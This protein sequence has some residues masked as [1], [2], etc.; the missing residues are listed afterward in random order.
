MVTGQPTAAALAE[1]FDF[2]DPDGRRIGCMVRKHAAIAA[3]SLTIVLAVPAHA[4]VNDSN[5]GS[6]EAVFLEEIAGDGIVM[7][8]QEAI[9]QGRAVCK[10]MAPPNGGSLWDAGQRV[11]SMHPDLGIGLALKLADHSVQDFCPNRGSF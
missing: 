3:L 5:G 4:D 8:S 10:L 11:V 1:N 9:R 2:S 7:N 6:T